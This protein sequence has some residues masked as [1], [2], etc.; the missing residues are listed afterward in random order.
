MNTRV[1][2]RP[3]KTRCILPAQGQLEKKVKQLAEIFANH[4]STD[5]AAQ[6]SKIKE[7]A[8]GSDG[9][10]YNNLIERVYGCET[11]CDDLFL[12]FMDVY[13]FMFSEKTSNVIIPCNCI[14]GIVTEENAMI[15]SDAII[16]RKSKDNESKDYDVACIVERKSRDI[17][18][19]LLKKGW[20]DEFEDMNTWKRDGSRRDKN[21]RIV[22]GKG[23]VVNVLLIEV[24][25]CLIQST[26]YAESGIMCAITDMN[27]TIK[28]LSAPETKIT[29]FVY[30]KAGTKGNALT[31]LHGEFKAVIKARGIDLKEVEKRGKEK[32]QRLKKAKGNK[33]DEKEPTTSTKL[34]TST[35]MLDPEITLSHV[36][37]KDKIEVLNI[38]N[39]DSDSILNTTQTQNSTSKHELTDI[40]NY[41]FKQLNNTWKKH[42]YNIRGLCGETFVQFSDDGAAKRVKDEVPIKFIQNGFGETTVGVNLLT[43]GLFGQ[44][45][46]HSKN[47]SGD[48][49]DSS[50][51]PFYSCVAR[52]G[53][54]M[55]LTDN[56]DYAINRVFPHKSQNI[57]KAGIYWNLQ[58]TIVF[59]KKDKGKGQAKQHYNVWELVLNLS[60]MCQDYHYDIKPRIRININEKIAKKAEKQQ[61]AQQ[62]ETQEIDKDKDKEKDNQEVNEYECK[63]VDENGEFYEDFRVIS[64]MISSHR[65]EIKYC[66]SV[67]SGKRFYIFTGDPTDEDPSEILFD[68]WR[69]MRD[70][71]KA[72]VTSVPEYY[73]IG[74]TISDKLLVDH[75]L[76]SRQYFALSIVD[77]GKNMIELIKA[78]EIE[79]KQE[80]MEMKDNLLTQLSICNIDHP[81]PRPE[82][83]TRKDNKDYLIDWVS[84]KFKKYDWNLIDSLFNKPLT[85]KQEKGKST[86]CDQGP[87]IRLW[88]DMTGN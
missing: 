23:I 52:G 12:S 24:M 10:K 84:G 71:E 2:Y 30:P 38:I 45:F 55:V 83:M 11:D 50:N 51:L 85:Q 6:F 39:F 78:K 77:C 20:K 60:I 54:I 62:P 46:I 42:G 57:I 73:E 5:Q 21:A 72:G 25:N 75:M 29:T 56:Q 47:R 28:I 86:R 16:V 14:G 27:D 74:L 63:S 26:T 32:Q 17:M 87:I 49:E 70:A 31:S 81:D 43:P 76:D 79:S 61:R 35:Q 36:S 67:M 68:T 3:C 66:E 18:Q 1:N 69:N 82:N 34:G 65:C 4:V 15:R 40:L 37:C 9:V 8:A 44:Y 80:A 88:T 19:F 33:D 58:D 13:N 41:N 22:N 7:T 59:S 64:K 53:C 48:F